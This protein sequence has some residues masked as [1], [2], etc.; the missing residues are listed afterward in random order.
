[1]TPH[2]KIVYLSV[3]SLVPYENNAR[4]NDAAVPFL[5]N[6]IRDHGFRNPILVDKDRVIIAGHTRLKAAK[7]LGMSEVPCIV[8][9]D[10]PPEKVASLRLADNKVSD[11]SG[12]DWEKLDLELK[13]LD[14]L[15]DMSAYGF[16]LPDDLDLGL[17]QSEEP[18]PEPAREEPLGGFE[19]MA[20]DDKH[21][22]IVTVGSEEEADDLVQFLEDQGYECKIL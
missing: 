4:E 16:D 10:L 18:E 22:V 21:R 5:A 20:F 9:T 6:S 8:I 14:D 11:Y 3:D 2:E 12:W 7:E 15:I 13:G 17:A 19:P 1:M